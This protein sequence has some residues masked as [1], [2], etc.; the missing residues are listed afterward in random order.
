M[1]ENITLSTTDNDFNVDRKRLEAANGAVTLNYWRPIQ[2]STFTI[3]TSTRR[4]WT[5]SGIRSA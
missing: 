2:L 5:G 1:N 3:T 4:T